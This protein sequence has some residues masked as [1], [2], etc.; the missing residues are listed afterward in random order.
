MGSILHPRTGSEFQANHFGIKSGSTLT[1]KPIPSSVVRYRLATAPRLP[2]PQGERLIAAAG[3]L[4]SR[5]PKNNI[6]LV[7]ERHDDGEREARELARKIKSDLVK[8]QRRA[9]LPAYWIEVLEDEC[10]LHSNLIAPL[11]IKEA[12]RLYGYSHD[13]RGCGENIKIKPIYSMPGLVGYLLKQGVDEA[14]GDSLRL[15]EALS[16]DMIAEGVIEPYKRTYAARSPN[17]P[18]AVH[19]APAVAAAETTVQIQPAPA[20]VVEALPSPPQLCLFTEADAP[21]IDVLTLVEE[22]RR[23]ENRTQDDVGRNTL[24]IRQADYSNVVIRRHDRF[25]AYRLSRAVAY[26]ADRLAA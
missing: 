4:E 12:R 7:G 18:A 16:S 19:D 9:D 1:A 2:K 6:Y 20:P 24:C 8:L 14:A 17:L 26:V 10:E 5:F 11:P 22:K 15:S 13:G 25:S 21:L 3:F 23:A